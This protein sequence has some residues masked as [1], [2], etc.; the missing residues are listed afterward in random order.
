[1]KISKKS[2][3]LKSKK[4]ILIITFVIS[5]ILLHIIFMI[6]TSTELEFDNYA[7]VGNP[8]ETIQYTYT[9]RQEGGFQ[10]TT[11]K[12]ENVVSDCIVS[13]SPKE[14]TL[15]SSDEKTFI[16]TVEIPKDDIDDP[17]HDR[18]NIVDFELTTITHSYVGTNE[19][20]VDKQ[21]VVYSSQGNNSEERAEELNN[22]IPNPVTEGSHAGTTWNIYTMPFVVII[23]I[24]FLLLIIEYKRR[25]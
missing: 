15:T 19:G 21:F 17:F 20:S 24:S 23:I 4:V 5:Y 2:L 25:S 22:D 14:C 10:T 3:N 13:V 1:M 6:P 9:I 11:Y 7:K 18:T 8:G 12:I 16:F